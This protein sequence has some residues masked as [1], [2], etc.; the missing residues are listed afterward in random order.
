MSSQAEQVIRGSSEADVDARRK[1][2]REKVPHQ[3]E[4]LGAIRYASHLRPELLVDGASNGP[5]DHV[6]RTRRAVVREIV[7][8]VVSVLG[9]L[10]PANEV[11]DPQLFR[12][13]QI[14]VLTPDG[15]IGHPVLV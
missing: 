13:C 14:E 15:S 10:V 2:D 8:P 12:G 5:V 9:L 1:E 3:A 4:C 6:T 7:V 11:A